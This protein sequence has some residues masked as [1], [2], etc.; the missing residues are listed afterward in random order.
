MKVAVAVI[1]DDSQ[2]VLITRRPEH[3]SHGGMWEFPGG[4]L[5]EGE[6]PAA[7][8]IREIKEEV[9]LDILDY[10]FLTTIFHDYV[11]KT[12]DLLIFR[13][14]RFQGEAYCR[15]SQ[16]DLRWIP[17]DELNSYEFPEANK[18]VIALIQ[19]QIA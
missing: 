12:V 17:V 13:V 7:A 11:T 9:G 5:E 8:L 14:D 10:C 6:L 15:E 1:F 18:Q 3:A 2:R 4:K 19:K 16:S